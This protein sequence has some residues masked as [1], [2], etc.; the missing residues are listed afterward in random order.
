VGAIEVALSRQTVMIDRFFFEWRGGR[1]MGADAYEGFDE[2]RALVAQYEAV[3]GA[4]DHAYW[5]D[6][7]PCALH[8]EE[9]EAIWSAIDEGDDW[10]PLYAKIEAVRRMGEA[11][12]ANA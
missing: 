11:Y 7:G 8:I 3:P 1:M 6:P 4:L 12:H 10:A 9:V 5:S 2:V